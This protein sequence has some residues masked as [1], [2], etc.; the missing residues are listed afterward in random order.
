[1]DMVLLAIVVLDFVG[2]S[3]D[4]QAAALKDVSFHGVGPCGAGD[5][6]RQNERARWN[7]S[8]RHGGQCKHCKVP[9]ATF[10]PFTLRSHCP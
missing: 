8:G 4:R 10:L 6:Y 5:L 3:L 9:A 2:L 7:F 1:M